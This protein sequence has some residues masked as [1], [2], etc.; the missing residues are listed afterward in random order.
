M[1]ILPSTLSKCAP[2][3]EESGLDSDLSLA[4]AC[5]Q[6]LMRR[7]KPSQSSYYLR[8]WKA[9]NLMRLRSGLISRPSHIKSF[10]ESWTSLLRVTPANHSQPQASEPEKTTLGTSG[11]GLQMEFGFCD[12][13]S[14]SL[15][16]SKA[17]SRWDS[18]ASSAIWKSWVTK[19]RGEYSLRVKSARLISA[20]GCSSWPTIT[21]QADMEANGPNGHSG[22]SVLPSHMALARRGE[23]SWPTPDTNNHRDGT[24]LRQDNNLHQGGMHGVSLHH[25]VEAKYGQAVPENPS[26]DGSRRE[27]WA[28]P[29]AF[30]FQSPEDTEH[31]QARAVYQKSKGVNLHKPIQTQV[32]HE[33][34]K[35]A[36]WRTPTVAEE[37][38]QGTST[39]IYLQNQVGATEK[40]WRTPR[41]N[42]PTG[43]SNFVA[44]NAD[45]GEHCSPSLTQQV[46]RQELLP[47]W[48]TPQA[49]EAGARVETLYTKDGHPARPGERAYRLTPSGKLVLQSQ[50]INQQ[51]EMV[52]RQES[53][54]TPTSFDWKNTDCSTQVYLSDQVEG[55]T[56]KQ[57][58]EARLWMTP[59]S[60]DLSS[61]STTTGRPKEMATNLSTQARVDSWATP[62]M[63]DSHLASTPEAAQ[64]RLDEGKVTLSRQNPGKLNPRWVETL[65]GL[66]VGWVMPSCA[67][68]VTIAPTNCDCSATASSRQQQPELF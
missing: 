46:S 62:I 41:A 34:E 55:R 9:G 26:T 27:S 38:N 65:M 40:V 19:C 25:A 13:D 14:V 8:E 49:Q 17:T 1:W 22:T 7:S 50:T 11:H 66:P 21:Q 37:K 52:S 5:A 58:A 16:M 67:S 59:R 23:M 30:C 43:D 4:T 51:V 6:S 57:S 33:V 24:T 48:R 64:K 15:K 35:Q 39:Q 54:R 68:P 29:N 61:G 63:G 31:W 20:S 44:R 53:W 12:Q 45:R 56:E 60:S 28:T 36:E 2:D 32:L 3:M 42:E 10:T 18:P 47:D